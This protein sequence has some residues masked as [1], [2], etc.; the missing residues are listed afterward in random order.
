MS[1]YVD[2]PSRGTTLT[3]QQVSQLRVRDLKRRL[4]RTH[5]YSAEEL[6][7]ILDKKELIQALAFAEHKLL[8]QQE[9]AVKRR[10][11]KRGL[12]TAVVLVLVVMCWPLLQQAY[13]IAAVNLVVYTDRKKLE[14]R[15]CWELRSRLGMLG[16][17]VMFIIDMLSAWLTGSILLSWFV[18]RN[19][20]FFPVPSVSIRPAE[21][22]GGH[23]AQTSLANYGVNVGPMAVSWILRFISGRVESWTGRALSGAQRAQRRAAREMETE[24]EKAARKAARKQA[25]REA[26]ARQAAAAAM[27]QYPP[28]TLPT[29]WMRANE[30]A[31]GQASELSQANHF[32]RHE[33]N[34]SGP[35]PVSG[36]KE[37]E[38]F[39][40]QLER[41]SSQLDDLD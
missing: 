4:A 18:T 1:D 31:Q 6:A 29:D 15:R 8:L 28:T 11:V 27:R 20:W 36:S 39:L 37:H 7:R 22:M 17:L 16:V 35:V 41:H 40:E 12:L 23:V 13:E 34:P 32:G 25:K 3:F 30:T 33:E 10:V 14:A 24:E 5:G 9:E 2:N 26:K 21:M 19:K 38:E